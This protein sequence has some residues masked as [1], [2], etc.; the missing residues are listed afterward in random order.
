M[1]LVT[2]LKNSGPLVSS[3]IKQEKNSLTATNYFCMH[4]Y[5]Y[6]HKC[7]HVFSGRWSSIILL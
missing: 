5:A 4:E 3:L 2:V 7:R 6:W 1:F